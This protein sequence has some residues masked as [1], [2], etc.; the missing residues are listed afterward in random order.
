M[1]SIFTYV[2]KPVRVTNSEPGLPVFVTGQDGHT[3]TQTPIQEESQ[4]ISRKIYL[5]NTPV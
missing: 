5:D 4:D 3:H 1:F 2:V